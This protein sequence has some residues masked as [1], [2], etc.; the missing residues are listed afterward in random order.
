VVDVTEAITDREKKR[1]WSKVEVRGPNE[2]WA[3]LGT[4]IRGGA[5]KHPNS[6]PSASKSAPS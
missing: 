5:T 3:W 4:T 1:F 2:C 6:P